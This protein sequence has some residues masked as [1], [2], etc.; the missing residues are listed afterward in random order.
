MPRAR[1]AV[2]ISCLCVS[3]VLLCPAAFA[4][5]D[6]LMPPIARVFRD[7]WQEEPFK[8]ARGLCID[9]WGYMAALGDEEA[10]QRL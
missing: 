8:A 6:D 5:G 1:Q 10:R 4:T 7:A 3:Y 9:G 2:R